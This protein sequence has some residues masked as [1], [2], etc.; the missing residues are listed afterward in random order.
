MNTSVLGAISI[1][2]LRVYSQANFAEILRE[3]FMSVL[4]LINN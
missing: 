4:T 1:F 2:V 3:D